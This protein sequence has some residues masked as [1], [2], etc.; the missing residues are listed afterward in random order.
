MGFH[1]YSDSGCSSCDA[2]TMEPFMQCF[3]LCVIFGFQISRPESAQVV[4]CCGCF[5]SDPTPLASFVE[6]RRAPSKTS[7]AMWFCDKLRSEWLTIRPFKAAALIAI[8]L[9]IFFLP[10][11]LDASGIHIGSD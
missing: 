6:R 11:I 8:A 5:S 10:T 9:I 7:L 3:F 4:P 2:C 1:G